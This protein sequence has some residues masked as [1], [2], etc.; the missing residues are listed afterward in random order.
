[1]TMSN[2]DEQLSKHIAELSKEKQPERDLFRGIELGI[3]AQRKS[4][5]KVQGQGVS[6]NQWLAIA[7]SV[8]LVT[9]LWLSAPFA[10]KP[11]ESMNDNYALVDAMSSQQQQQVSSLLASYQSTPALTED[12]QQQL[13]ELDDAAD[14]IKTALKEDPDN[15]ALIKMLHHVY[16]QQ[17]A[18]I[19]RVH[20]PKWQQI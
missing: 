16:Q 4:D 2:F 3:E 17:I 14:A 8:C 13:K 1:M 7:A 18:L 15:S 6:A 10:F 12:W 20:A 11:D 9:V 19:E 5:E